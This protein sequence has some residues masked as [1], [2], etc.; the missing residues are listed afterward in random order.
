MAQ[1]VYSDNG[2]EVKGIGV[3][4]QDAVFVLWGGELMM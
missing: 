2:H 4:L 1:M 3:A